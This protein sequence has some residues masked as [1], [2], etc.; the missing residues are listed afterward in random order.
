MYTAIPFFMMVGSLFCNPTNH[1]VV[2][3][4]PPVDTVRTP[5]APLK[6]ALLVGINDYKS[7]TISDLDGCVNDVESMKATLIGKFG[8]HEENILILKDSAATHAHIVE[9][10]QNHLI[11]RAQENDIVVF[12]YSGHGSQMQDAPGGDEIDGWDETIVPYDS[13]QGG[14]YDITDD[15]MN[16][17]LSRLSRKTKNITWILDSCHSGTAV[18]GLGAGKERR[19]P[20]DERTPPPSPEYAL[21]ERGTSQ[22]LSDIRLDSIQYVLI[23][24]C[25]SK[26]SSFEHYAGGTEH[27]ALTY[28]LT[29]ELNKAKKAMTYRDIMDAVITNV[30]TTYPNQRPQLEGTSLDQY[31]FSDSTS[32]AQPYV[33]A[34]PVGNKSVKLLAGLVHG[35]TVGSVFY[36]YAPGAKEFK[37]TMTAIAR[38]ILS[39]VGSFESTG[40]I[41]K[42]NVDAKNSRAIE[43]QHSYPDLK[44]IVYYKNL[45][46]SNTLKSIKT[47]LSSYQFISVAPEERNYQI[48]L[49]E[50]GGKI[51]IEGAETNQLSQPVP[52]NQAHA[53]DVM[54][55]KV[56]QWVKWYNILAIANSNASQL[57]EMTLSKTNPSAH[58]LNTS[59]TSLRLKSGDKYTCKAY[60]KSDKDV[61]LSILDI[62]TDGSIS[63]I[64]P[65]QEGA[66]ELLTS[67]REVK[68]EFETFVP[69]G[70][71]SV[72]D[73]IKLFVTSAPID[74][75]TLT[76]PMIKG[77]PPSGM[78]SSDPLTML[79][80]QALLD[81]PRGSAPVNVNQGV[82]ATVQGT[83]AI[84]R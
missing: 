27:G 5:G 77:E 41:V 19:I 29:E 38:I 28:F 11:N 20:R 53:A 35:L 25:L 71:D 79:L 22:D 43:S 26:Q 50:R 2:P 36:V 1:D 52:V 7:K 33:I 84:K 70:R 24:G 72:T 56:L 75:H 32:I 64:Y 44:V 34:S 69:D 40:K 8:F 58:D 83:V 31:V 55:N 45:A 66:S 80:N 15:E 76:Q 12:H 60:N 78:I 48:L 57:V 61:Y 62:S 47:A 17:L 68:P 63:V 82:W 67:K 73:I 42:G 65:A 16:G 74:F 23:S 54:T 30:Q 59:S 14:I 10:I 39:E 3:P 13:R 21:G 81:T 46:A 37:D 9:A 51:V 49:E 6:L 4:T 18:K